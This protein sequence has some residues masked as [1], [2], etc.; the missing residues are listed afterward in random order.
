MPMIQ[1]I[2]MDP[3]VSSAELEA[4]VERIQIKVADLPVFMIPESEVFVFFPKDLL[5]EGLGEELIAEIKGLYIKQERTKEVLSTMRR[6]IKDEL[7]KFTLA[8][9][10]QCRSVEVFIGQM[11]EPDE[12]EMQEITRAQIGVGT[13]GLQYVYDASEVPETDYAICADGKFVEWKGSPPYT[14]IEAVKMVR[15]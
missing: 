5:S 9:L 4:L 15:S 7:K 13:E 1:I 3:N 8:S 11:I 10:P 6:A 12:L 14:K 2:G